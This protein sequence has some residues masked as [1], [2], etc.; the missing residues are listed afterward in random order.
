MATM[1]IPVYSDTCTCIPVY[2]YSC[3][4]IPIYL[5]TCISVGGWW[6]CGWP[7]EEQQ[8][9]QPQQQTAAASRNISNSSSS[10]DIQVYRY[11]G[12]QGYRDAATAIQVYKC[13]SGIC[14]TTVAKLIPACEFP[15]W[16]QRWVCKV[17][18]VRLEHN[19][20]RNAS[21]VYRYTGI[22]HTCTPVCFCCWET[23]A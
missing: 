2:L 9:Q 22:V 11:T 12:I 21:L 4:C 16:L 18:T 3:C 17:V 8:Q 5:Y 10:T 1:C 14:D 23:A 15:P 19:C 13:T 20:N 6:A 7:E